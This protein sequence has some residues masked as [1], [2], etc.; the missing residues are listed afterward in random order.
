MTAR[1]M[2]LNLLSGRRFQNSHRNPHYTKQ[3]HYQ[4]PELRRP[5]RA[6]TTS[7]MNFPH[8]RSSDFKKFFGHRTTVV[9]PIFL[10]FFFG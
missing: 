1:C 10:E 3:A 8:D 4:R 9:G 2:L 7:P 6:P 5:E